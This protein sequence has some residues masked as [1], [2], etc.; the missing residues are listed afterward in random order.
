MLTKLWEKIESAE[1]RFRRS[2]GKDISTPRA[3]ALSKFHYHVFDHA[4]LRMFWTNFWQL[5]PG[6]WR[7]NQPTHG[8]FE[9]YAAMGIKTV[10]TLR[11]EEKYAHYLFEKESCEKLGLTLLHAKLW[12]RMAPKRER[13]IDLIDTLRSAERPM[14]FHCKSGADRA[15]FASA[16]YLMVFEGVP[17]E[18][19]RKQMGLKY[20]HL[21]FTKTGI[22]GYILDTYAAR[23][24][25]DPISFEDWIRTEYDAKKLQ[26]GFDAKRPPEEMA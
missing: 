5:A 7:S 1:R 26:T 6:V 10:I 12:A 13:V 16:V 3:R 8:R 25:R 2:F 19:A 18:E 21:E 24:R 9:K 14:I 17:V 11:G 4:F 22:Q 15:G 20:V 23:N